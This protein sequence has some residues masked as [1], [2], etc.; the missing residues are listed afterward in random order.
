MADR[1]VRYRGQMYRVSD[2]SSRLGSIGQSNTGM[3]GSN[4]LAQQASPQGPMSLQDRFRR[5]SPVQ[6]P[7]VQAPTEQLRPQTLQERF[8]NRTQQQQ[9][10]QGT[11][12]TMQERF[13][14]IAQQQQQTTPLTMQE[15]FANTAGAPQQP[16]PAPQVAPQQEAQPQSFWTKPFLSE[17][18]GTGLVSALWNEAAVPMSSP[19]G[20][21][22]VGGLRIYLD[23]GE[24]IR[25]L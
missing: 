18:K 8:A 21:G 1:F 11:P 9:A 16:T 17:S 25:K 4:R 22:M 14:N 12:L 5:T 10:P 19:A 2:R 7:T 13:A 20:I 23:S 15:R 3:P 6:Q 24:N